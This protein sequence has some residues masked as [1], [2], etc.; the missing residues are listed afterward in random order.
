MKSGI[1]NGYRYESKELQVNEDRW[2]KR[3][4]SFAR[5][6]EDGGD[7]ARTVDSRILL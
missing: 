5:E 2:N 3:N 4:P 6:Q 7:K 1:W